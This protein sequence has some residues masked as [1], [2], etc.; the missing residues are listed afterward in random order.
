MLGTHDLALFVISGLLLLFGV[1]TLVRSFLTDG[2]P[3]GA[4][5]WKAIVLVVGSVI[6]FGLLLPTAGLI[7]AMTV[8]VLMSA[9]ASE[10][11]RFEWKATAGLVAL[12]VFCSLVF[13]KGLGVPMPLLGSWFGQ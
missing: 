7:V 11:F 1:I 13:V 9:A 5:A 8:L 12:V 3:V 6:A 4:F 2:E 10:K